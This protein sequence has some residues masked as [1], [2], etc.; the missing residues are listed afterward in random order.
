M[1][2]ATTIRAYDWADLAFGSKKPLR[3]LQAT[4]IA[5][6][7]E[8]SEKRFKQLIAAYLPKGN[9]VLGISKEA[10]VLGFED[11]P[12][13]RMLSQQAIQKVIDAVNAAG[14]GRVSITVLMY[15]QRELP[16][17]LEKLRFKH[18]V[19]VNGS[20]QH[21]LHS[22]P[23]YYYLAST[24]TPYDMVSPFTDEKEAEAYEH[25]MNEHITSKLD[26]RYPG[27]TF[28]EHQML[29]IAQDVAKASY[30]Y[31]FQT[32]AALG[33]RVAGKKTYALIG[34]GVNKVVPYQTYA[35]H[36]GSLREKNF[37]PANDLNYYDTIH[38]E[39]DTLINAQKNKLSLE[40]TTLFINL[41]PCPTCARMLS[42]TDITE[43]VYQIDHS[44]GYAVKM[45][46][47][48]GK[49]VRRVVL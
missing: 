26:R 27:E 18:V 9:I 33:R 48:A 39:V 40:K 49:T 6:P 44:D 42:Q 13:F 21:V 37:S 45:L 16:Y 7:R 8:L 38:A 3:V 23:A 15:F 17:I 20:W 12:Q 22:S 47:T 32:G 2:S 31:S 10:Y 29:E 30:D 25:R 19:F 24:R 1:S 14:K 46:E 5:A 35:M 43:F 11:Q 4:F 36:F 28:T 41:M 34:A